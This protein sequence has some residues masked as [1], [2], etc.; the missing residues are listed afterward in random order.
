[1][2]KRLALVQAD[3]WAKRG[4]AGDISELEP[5]LA[6]EETCTRSVI[7]NLVDDLAQQ[8]HLLVRHNKGLR[9]KACNVYRA[10]RQFSF[11]N[12]TPCVPRPCAA[13]VISQFR[14]KKRQHNA[15]TDDSAYGKSVFP[16]AGACATSAPTS[17]HETS[18]VESGQ[19]AANLI[20]KCEAGLVTPLA[21]VGGH[22]HFDRF[23]L[24]LSL[25]PESD[26]AHTQQFSD[27]L[28]LSQV[29]DECDESRRVSAQMQICDKSGKERNNP[30]CHHAKKGGRKRTGK[31]RKLEIAEG[32]VNILH[33]NVT[34]WSEHAKQYILTSDFDAALISETH[35]EREKLVTA[36]KE[37]R[38]FSWA[39]TGSA[40]QTTVQVREYSH[41]CA[42]FGFLSPCLYVHR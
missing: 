27:Y 25:D 39:G 19:G 13:V 34:T 26:V 23:S 30:F 8:G 36:A 29:G 18:D 17:R 14:N 12:R 24:L 31:K 20:S 15:H 28:S 2:A 9:C 37:A 3:T 5:L 38:K 40:L 7:G 4:A 41:V 6:V 16:S 10:D 33:C 1:M 22:S 42:H 32:V 21:R 11:W 35:L